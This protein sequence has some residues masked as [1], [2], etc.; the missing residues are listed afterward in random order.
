MMAQDEIWSLLEAAAT[1]VLLGDLEATRVRIRLLLEGCDD[2]RE[3]LLLFEAIQAIYVEFEETWEWAV[4]LHAC[5]DVRMCFLGDLKSVYLDLQGDADW[6]EA[7]DKLFREGLDPHFVGR[8]LHYDFSP[9]IFPFKG[10]V[11]NRIFR[12]YAREVWQEEEMKR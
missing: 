11:Q 5:K 8:E 6:Q 1:A 12:E 10:K 3:R 7:A 2:Y 9:E 4:I